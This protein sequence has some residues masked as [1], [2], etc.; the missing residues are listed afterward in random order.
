MPS[1][2]DSTSSLSTAAAAAV[3]AGSSRG[4]ADTPPLVFGP[5][6][7]RCCFCL[8]LQKGSIIVG[9]ANALVNALGFGW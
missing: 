1:S 7:N 5:P 9:I 4:G 3:G 8:T 2:L 6:D